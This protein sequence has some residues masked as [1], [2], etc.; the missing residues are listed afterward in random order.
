MNE[1]RE[2]FLPDAAFS[3]DQHPRIGRRYV[4]RFFKHI[5]NGAASAENDRTGHG[6]SSFQ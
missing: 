4:P 6:C 2:H 3:R 5:Q 1:V